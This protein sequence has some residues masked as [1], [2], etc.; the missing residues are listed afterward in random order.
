MNDISIHKT[1]IDMDLQE[2]LHNPSISK[3]CELTIHKVLTKQRYGQ[4][5]VNIDTTLT[6][7]FASFMYKDTCISNGI[8]AQCS[9]NNKMYL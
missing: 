7:Y 2:P 1:N 6:Y 4:E 9:K 8:F 5:F 3:N